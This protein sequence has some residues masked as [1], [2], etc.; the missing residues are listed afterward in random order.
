MKTKL[1]GFSIFSILLLSLTPAFAD[2]TSVDLEKPVFTDDESIVFTGKE[3]VGGQSVFVIIRT[4]SGSFVDMASDPVSNS[5]GTFTTLPRA[6]DVI[7]NYEGIYEATA[8]TNTQK[9]ED[10]ISIKLEYDGNKVFLVPD[11]I[12]SLKSIPD[13]TIEVGKTV[14]FTAS[15]TD[16]SIENVV[17]SLENEPSGATIDPDSGKFVWTPTSSHGNI[18]DVHYR[19][20]VIANSG[21]QEDKDRVIVTVKQA[22]EEPTTPTQPTTPTPPEPLQIPAPFVDQT[23]DPQS[24]VDRYQNEANYKEWFDDNFH[25]YDSIYH[26]VGLEEPSSSVD[27][28]K[29]PADDIKKEKKYGICGPGTKLIDG[30]CTIVEKP[31]AKPWW[32]FW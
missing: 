16:N 23:K 20:D 2:V 14:T 27:D 17:Y 28:D 19:F 22:F 13:Q 15:I 29:K 30:V 24:Y 5:D 31:K 7:F 32:Q 12:L 1:F 26:A 18:Q 10:G 8:F 25:E 3:S 6:V 9:E 4:S 21:S 11:V